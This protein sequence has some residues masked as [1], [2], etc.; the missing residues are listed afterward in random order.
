[1][2]PY[3]ADWMYWVGFGLMMGLEE[4]GRV[5]VGVWVL[6]FVPDCVFSIVES[7]KDRYFGID[8]IGLGV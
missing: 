5:G 7:S 3:I 4:R 1:M 8:W 2:I 6:S